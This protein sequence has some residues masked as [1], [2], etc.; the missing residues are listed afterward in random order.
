MAIRDQYKVSMLNGKELII[1]ATRQGGSVQLL[2]KEDEDF[3]VFVEK[4]KSH[5]EVRSVHV[6]KQFI[7]YVEFK[8]G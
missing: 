4:T 6:A 2:P 8:N 3:L 5:I 7:E 1:S